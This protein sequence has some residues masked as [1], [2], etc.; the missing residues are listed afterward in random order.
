MVALHNDARQLRQV[1]MEMMHSN[2]GKVHLM[3][4]DTDHSPI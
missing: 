1:A 3:I 2:S 4:V